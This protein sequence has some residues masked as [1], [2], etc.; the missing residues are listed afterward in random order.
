MARYQLDCL[1]ASPLRAPATTAAQVFHVYGLA[2]SRTLFP[3]LPEGDDARRN[4]LRTDQVHP[5][6]IYE[7]EAQAAIVFTDGSLLVGRKSED[8]TIT[9]LPEIFTLRG[10]DAMTAAGLLPLKAYSLPLGP[11][12]AFPNP[13]A[14]DVYNAQIYLYPNGPDGSELKARARRPLLHDL[15][16]IAAKGPRPEDE[17]ETPWF[18]S[19]TWKWVDGSA[20]AAHV[21]PA[22]KDLVQD[23]G[24]HIASAL[25]GADWSGTQKLWV[26][27]APHPVAPKVQVRL[28]L[29]DTRPPQGPAPQPRA[30]ALEQIL[31]G[32]SQQIAELAKGLDASFM[33]VPESGRKHEVALVPVVT[34]TAG[35]ISHHRRR[36]LSRRFP[37]PPIDAL[38]P[39]RRKKT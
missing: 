10:P 1:N 31:P 13:D 18:I 29:Q 39:S 33:L 16:E 3:H 24:D 37:D 15:A 6:N 12:L 14:R 22:L 38:L 17:V 7:T 35:P 32:I 23:A 2:Q 20:Y 9:I 34:W 5:F 21:D 8:G 25:A 11:L 26:D 36:A 27:C 4:A 28:S 19:R 30:I